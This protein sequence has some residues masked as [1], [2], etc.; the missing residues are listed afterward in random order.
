MEQT[1]TVIPPTTKQRIELIL[2]KAPEQAEQALFELGWVRQGVRLPLG[3]LTAQRLMGNFITKFKTDIAKLSE[4]ANGCGID[5][6]ALNMIVT[7]FASHGDLDRALAEIDGE[8]K[9]IASIRR[10]VVR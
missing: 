6:L 10:E 8:K 5:E 4:S 7:D 2:A 9:Y 3:K 1:I